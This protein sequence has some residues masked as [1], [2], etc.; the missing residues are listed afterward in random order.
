MEAVKQ[1][2]EINVSPHRLYEVLTDFEAYPGFVPNQS[3]VKI[4][5]SEDNRW[6]VQFELSIVK[7]LTYTLD[8]VGEPG[9]SL[10][11]FLVEGDMMK[12]NT[13]GWT[14]EENDAGHTLAK[15][16]IEVLFGGFV[17][18]S[19]SRSLIQKTLPSNLAA[20]KQEAERRAS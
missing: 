12:S 8:L 15:Y 5:Q 13:G 19:V 11:W 17:P 16:E 20:F 4:L 10:R 6:R 1:S 7:K 3:A 18:K 9:R 2:V 14:L